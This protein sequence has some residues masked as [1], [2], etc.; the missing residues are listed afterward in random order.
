MLATHQDAERRYESLREMARN[1][2]G[3]ELPYTDRSN[4]HLRGI[5]QKALLQAKL[6][7]NDPKRLVDWPWDSG[8]QDYSYRNPKRF[9]LATWYGNTLAGLSLGRPSYAGTR[10]R[11]EFIESRPSSSPLKGRIVPITI[12]VAELY[13]N[14]IGADELRIIDPVDQKLVEYYTSFGYRYKTAVSEKNHKHYLVK[15]IL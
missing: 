10:L 11:L 4:I 9:E 6:W 2:I 1:S 3:N 5:C 14:I 13:A 15:A 12:S 7:D 8:Y